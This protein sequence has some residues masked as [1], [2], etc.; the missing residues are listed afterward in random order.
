MT[1]TK[2]KA[3][4]AA[5]AHLETGYEAVIG[6]EVHC[7]L[8]TNTKLFCACA[9][10]FGQDPN[11]NTCPVCLALPGALP[12]LNEKVVEYALRIGEALSFNVPTRSVFHRKNYFYPDMPKNFQTSQFDEPIC[13]DGHLDIVTSLGEKTIRIER[14]HMEEDTG[15]STHIGESGRIHGADY[16]LVDYNRAGVP[17]MEI[18]S[19]PD[20]SNSEEA[21]AYVSELRAVLKAIGVSDVKMEE[22]SMRVDAN[23]SV[24]PI[25]QEELG[26]RA[27]IKN[28]NS[29][30]S[31]GRAVDYEIMRQIKRVKAG[32]KIVQETRHW[33]ENEGQTSSMR[34]K[35]E[36]N[37]YRYFEE[38]DLVPVAPTD[39]MRKMVHESMPELPNAK[40]ERIVNEW[41][42][43]DSDAQTLVSN[44]EMFDL[45]EGAILVSD[46]SI[47]KDATNM[48]II[49]LAAILNESDSGFDALKITSQ[50]LA[51][52]CTMISDGDVSRNQAKTL[53][54]ELANHGGEAKSLADKMGLKQVSDTS[55]LE[56]I[57]DSVFEEFAQDVAS[58]SDADEGKQ[59][60]LQGFLMG[61][62]MA[63]SKGQGNPQ[64]F[65]QI[66]S[67]KLG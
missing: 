40:R 17:L 44:V 48:A 59:K 46:A 3:M 50:N 33:N 8:S 66:I 22:G 57:I 65:N 52:I 31:L 10:E 19:R 49:E 38:P 11:T 62:A 28:M 27:E 14:A 30:R 25:G 29:L 23:V 26:T 36:A 55:A 7:E 45:V 41:K 15:K 9:N 20:I 56:A 4:N 39:A 21:R 37:D 12:V 5:T 53:L 6:L 32:E 2:Q 16:S 35:E 64:L 47:A 67:K 60:K 1:T 24:R 63:A 18:V 42:I 61:K 43:N 54:A 51:D 34:S 58:Y 13:M